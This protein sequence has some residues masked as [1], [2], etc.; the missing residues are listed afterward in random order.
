MARARITDAGQLLRPNRRRAKAN[1]RVVTGEEPDRMDRYMALARHMDTFQ[2]DKEDVRD[3]LLA[4][5]ATEEEAFLAYRA[6]RIANRE[7]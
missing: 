3:A 4:S 6:A 5:G 2:A 1:A 7:G